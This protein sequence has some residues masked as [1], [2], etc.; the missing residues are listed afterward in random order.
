ME[1]K[2]ECEVEVTCTLRVK[3]AMPNTSASID[4][5]RRDAC[6][7]AEC[8]VKKCI[9]SGDPRVSE[10]QRVALIGG[11]VDSKA[12]RLTVRDCVEQEEA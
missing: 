6:V 3:V 12:G 9:D 4:D 5:I 1:T 8:Q 11:E 2:I 7:R 10:G